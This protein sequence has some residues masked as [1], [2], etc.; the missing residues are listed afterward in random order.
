MRRLDSNQIITRDG[1]ICP[2]EARSTLL[3]LLLVHRQQ[4]I[5][6]LVDTVA[7]GSAGLLGELE[8]GLGG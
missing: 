5:V 6:I 3:L 8:E 2:D 4:M 7:V 1:R